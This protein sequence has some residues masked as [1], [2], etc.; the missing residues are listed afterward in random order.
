MQRDPAHLLDMLQACERL[1][2]FVDGMTEAAF[3]AESKTQSAVQHQLIILG[4]AAKR[5]SRDLRELNPD[6]PWSAVAG[7]RDRLTHAYDLVDL[8][9]VWQTAETAVPSLARLLRR[10]LDKHPADTAD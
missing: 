6:V 2:G 5:L 4:E 10:I 8:S 1:R 3:L 7:M 9:I